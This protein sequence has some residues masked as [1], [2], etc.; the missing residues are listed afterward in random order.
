MVSVFGLCLWWVGV[1]FD[2]R[3]VSLVCVDV[4]RFVSS[5]TIIGFEDWICNIGFWLAV[6]TFVCG[7]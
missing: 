5:V 1:G 6:V 2:L 7:M 4:F 3:C